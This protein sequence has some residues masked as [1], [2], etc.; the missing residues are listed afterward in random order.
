[1]A[2]QYQRHHDFPEGVRALLIDKDKKPQW[3]PA[4]F[5]EV[6]DALVESHFNL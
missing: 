6:S 2:K 5:A 1:L 3:S 4:S